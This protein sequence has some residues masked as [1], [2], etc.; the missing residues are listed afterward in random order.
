METSHLVL[1]VLLFL[2]IMKFQNEK[3]KK[4]AP[5]EGYINDTLAWYEY[6]GMMHPMPKPAPRQFYEDQVYSH[7]R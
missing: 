4:A 2:G 6:T 1:L 7:W 3:K 5:A